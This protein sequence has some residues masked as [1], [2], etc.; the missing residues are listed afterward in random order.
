M[1]RLT[2]AVIGSIVRRSLRRKLQLAPA[3]D[4]LKMNLAA[5]LG[6]CLLSLAWVPPRVQG[7]SAQ[8]AA[9]QTSIATDTNAPAPQSQSSDS[10]SQPQTPT[11]Q[12]PGAAEPLPSSTGQTTSPANK[13]KPSAKRHHSQKGIY[14]DCSNSSAAGSMK[15]D[16]T[17]ERPTKTGSPSSAPSNPCPPPKKVVHNGGSDEPTIQLIGGTTADKA[18]NERSTEQL[19]AATEENLKKIA[20]RQLNA[21]EQETVSQIKQFMEQS[22]KAV[23]SGDPERGH[24]LAMKARLLSDELVKP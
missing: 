24:N 5:I 10:P 3:Q 8:S 4:G 11:T 15:E 1:L 22:K 13:P 9:Q 7:F 23:A 21:S 19:T 12:S 14:P 18:S 2:D 6:F 20:G 17:K 16:S